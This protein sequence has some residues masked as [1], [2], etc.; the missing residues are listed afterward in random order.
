MNR[1]ATEADVIGKT[2]AG[3]LHTEWEH[4]EEFS[5]CNFFVDLCDRSLIGINRDSLMWIDAGDRA[6]L[7]LRNVELDCDFPAMWSSD[8]FTGVG[9]TIEKVLATSYGSIYLQ[10]S[11][12]HYLT[13][14]EEEFQTALGMHDYDDFLHYARTSEYFDYWTKEPC[15]FENMRAVDVFVESSIGD[16]RLWQ[17]R[18]LFLTIGRVEDG[19]ICDLVCEPNEPS[20][21]GWKARFVVP[22]LGTYRIFVQRQHG[23]FAVDV[24]IDESVIERGRV[25]VRVV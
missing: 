6:S 3:I 24:R 11:G 19:R 13:V 10:M 5:C 20:G 14:E 25:D 2:V 16:L 4:W 22:V 23:D 7:V 1:P 15:F 17:A 8:G 21:N 9:A 12:K 18:E